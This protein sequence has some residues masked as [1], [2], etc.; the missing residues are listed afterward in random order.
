MQTDSNDAGPESALFACVSCKSELPAAL[1]SRACATCGATYERK[2][3]FVDFVSS[4]S[5]DE[6]QPLLLQ[7]PSQ[8]LFQL[9]QVVWLYERGWRDSFERSGF[10]GPDAEA[11][12]ARAFLGDAPVLLD[13]SCGTGLLSRRLAADGRSARV[14]ALDYSAQ[15][16]TEA[17]SRDSNNSFE[18]VRADIS[19]MPFIDSSVDAAIAGAALH[20]WPRPQDAIRELHRVLRDGAPV[21]ATTFRR[22]AFLPKPDLPRNVV[23]V[24]ESLNPTSSYRFFWPEE[25]VWLFKAANFREVN[26]ETDR[27]FLTVRCRK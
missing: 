14:I 2:S 23:E 12:R 5:G 16:L 24:V 7:P 6:A 27:G 20:C 11:V 26:V 18:R 9:P 19:A 13:A 1:D 10:P 21:F 3:G 8:L 17:A 25:L 22:G 4:A 15:M